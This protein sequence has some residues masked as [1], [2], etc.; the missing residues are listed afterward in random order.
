[1]LVY[2][3]AVTANVTMAEPLGTVTTVQPPPTGGGVPDVAVPVLLDDDDDDEEE[4]A[5]GDAVAVVPV[6]EAVSLLAP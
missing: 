1:M 6:G 5:V 2:D 4:A 3:G